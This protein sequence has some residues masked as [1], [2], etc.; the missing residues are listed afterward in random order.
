VSAARTS[1]R[2]LRLY[3]PGWRARYGEE[4]EA[5]IVESSGGG[6]V[7]WGMR[8][9]VVRAGA[10]ERMR[11][12]GL[13]GGA[14]PGEQV[15]GGALLVLCAWAVLVVGGLVVQKVAEHWQDVTP[16]G[17]RGVPSGAFAA[18]VAAAVCGSVLVLAGIA[19]AGPSLAALLRDGGWA[20][21][22][23]RVIPAALLTVA[24]IAATA[25]LAIWAGGLTPRERNGHDVAYGIAFVAWA[26]LGVACLT[27]WTAAAAATAR[28]LR[29]GERTLSIEA[30]LAVAVSAAMCVATAAAAVWWVAV[31]HAAPW[32]LAGHPVGQHGSPVAPQLVV[33]I[34][35]MGLASVL[36]VAGSARAVRALPA[37]GGEQPG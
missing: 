17:S 1:G 11:A 13:S 7:P 3:P 14:A 21:L 19:S 9:D 24:A 18:L 35:L 6:R 16:A 23:R 12:A 4:L 5:L 33:A 15:R 28:R 29:L 31:A 34:A 10:R 2:L 27:A 37:L 32:F 20:A 30:W 26:L 8:L 36:A 22:R 25:V